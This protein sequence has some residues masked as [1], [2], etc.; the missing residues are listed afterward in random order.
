M[1]NEKGA[2][3]LKPIVLNELVAEKNSRL[4]ARIPGFVYGLI[5]RLLHIREINEIIRRYGHLKGIPFIDAVLEYFDVKVELQ[6][7]ENLPA[8]GQYIFAS[9]HP[10]GGFD[11]LMLIKA[12]NDRMGKSLFLV[13]DELTKI[14]PLKDL[15]IPINKFGDQRRSASLIN[16]AYDSDSQILIFPAGLA[17]RKIKG[18]IID[19]TWQK[20]FIQ[21]SVE[22]HRDVVPVYISGKNSWFFYWLANFR[23]WIGIRINIEMFLLS[24]E[25]FKNRGKTFV[26]SFGKPIH[27][28]RFDRTKSHAEWACTVKDIVYELTN[29]SN[30]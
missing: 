2:S 10:L 26:I 19:L 11:G 25:L 1:E 17:S 7:Q 18:K 4:A 28:S 24:D 20:H 9:N 6:G 5:N 12:V 30:K 14:P 23:K 22:H 21:K 13:R 15:F 8:S 16:E 3:Q 29:K 27:W